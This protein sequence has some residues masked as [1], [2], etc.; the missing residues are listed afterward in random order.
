MRKLSDDQLKKLFREKLDSWEVDVPEDSFGFI[1]SALS[2]FRG[3]RIARK[4]FVISALIFVPVMISLVWTNDKKNTYSLKKST[5]LESIGKKPGAPGTHSRR[6]SIPSEPLINSAP[7]AVSTE[8]GRNIRERYQGDLNDSVIRPE[9]IPVAGVPAVKMATE[10]TIDPVKKRVS[11]Q[12]DVNAETITDAAEEKKEIRYKK[13]RLGLGV[14]PFLNYKR[15]VPNKHDEVL[16]YKFK[17]PGSFH[18]SRWGVKL[19][20]FV[21]RPL[22]GNKTIYLEGSY[23]RY[24]S[25]FLYSTN[26]IIPD[27]DNY[28]DVN[29]TINGLALGGGLKYGIK[30]LPRLPLKLDVGFQYQRILN[31][32]DDRQLSDNRNH[33]M[34][35]LGIA[36]DHQWN[37]RFLRIQPVVSYSLTSYGTGDYRFFPFWTGINTAILF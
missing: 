37:G 2:K 35:T 15:I 26:N 28:R 27:T 30:I 5:T 31:G 8:T 18:T 25:Y 24:R 10:I 29:V 3:K 34:L 14:M 36:G 1:Q 12:P 32:F 13:Y 20:G 19:S 17:T 11:A 33:I 9:Y 16:V 21:E 4:L 7:L 22:T 6:Q 23:F